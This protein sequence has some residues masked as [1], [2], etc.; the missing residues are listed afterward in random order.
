MTF[1]L[2]NDAGTETARADSLQRL[3]LPSSPKPYYHEDGIVI[4]HGDSKE[5]LPL[6]TCN[7]IITDPPYPK[8]Y[9]PLYGWLAEA[10]ARVLP[11]GW[12]LLAMAGPS[13]LPEILSAMSAAIRY[14]WTVGYVTLGGQASQIWPRKVIANWK[15]VLWFV[16]GDYSGKWVGDCVTS[17]NNDKAHHKWGQSET[18]M[19]A[20]VERFSEPGQ[21]ICDPF[22][23]AGTTLRAAKDLGRQAIG[24]EVSERYCE[25]AA[26]RMSQGVLWRQNAEVSH[27]APPAASDKPTAQRGGVA[28]D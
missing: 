22:M 7:H 23:G 2:E 16:N 12:N 18:G 15:P 13:Y 19:T 25:V 21:V 24:I 11:N 4:Y 14:H 27:A 10:A 20:L 28:L 1:A 5:L 8:E 6:M 9:L 17:Q 3:V 26:R